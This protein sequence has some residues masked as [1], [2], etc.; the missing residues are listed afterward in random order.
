MD[1]DRLWRAHCL[2]FHKSLAKMQKEQGDAKALTVKSDA[3]S[4]MD[5][6]TDVGTPKALGMPTEKPTPLAV[7]IVDGKALL[8][9]A[10]PWPNLEIKIPAREGKSPTLQSAT[11]T[12]DSSKKE[13][14]EQ[15]SISDAETTTKFRPAV[16]KELP[17][18]KRL[19]T[20]EVEEGYEMMCE[21]D[22]SD[23]KKEEKH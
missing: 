13:L 15:M 2:N 1:L 20:K 6:T 4:D 10:K 3:K 5:T 12:P 23:E 22:F 9:P 7:E 18:A 19:R 8:S 17:P 16:D 14:F 21:D 11:P